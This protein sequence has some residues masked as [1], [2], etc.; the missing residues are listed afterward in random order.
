M[1]RIKIQHITNYTVVQNDFIYD[2]A[3]STFDKGLLLV[4]LSKK[5]DYNFSIARIASPVLHRPYCK[6]NQ[7]NSC[8][9]Q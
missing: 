8:K 9:G 4:M 1:A 7:G 3:I 6:G 5:D 2:T